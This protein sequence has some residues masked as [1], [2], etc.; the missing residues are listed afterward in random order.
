MSIY[1][2]L[3][4]LT[5]LIGSIVTTI[6]GKFERLRDY[7]AVLFSLISALFASLL[8]PSAL[9][10]KIIHEQINWLSLYPLNIKAGILAD[11]LS[12]IMANI[13]GWISFLIMFYSLEYMKGERDL[14]RYWFF[15]NFFIG[16][17]QLIV[18]SDNLL[19]LFF[20]W[21]GVGLA[22]YALIGFWHTDEKKYWVGKEGHKALGIDLAYSPTH[23][24]MKAFLFTKL[25][26]I[27]FLIG[28]LILFSYSGT[29]EYL[30][31]AEDTS[32]ARDL[33]S[34][35]LLP[36]VALL[37]FG[38]AVGKSAQF[39]LHE[40][41][42]DAM[43]G[44]TSVS[45]LIH[46]ATMVKAGVF[47]VA[48]LGPIFYLASREVGSVY[49]F[50][51]V[52]A[53][54]GVFT[55]FL[56]ATQAMVSK[57]LKKVIAYSTVSQIGYMMLALGVAGLSS[58]FALAY[59]ASFFHLMSHSIFKASLF[60]GAGALIHVTGT[61]FID[62][63]GGLRKTMKLTYLSM[64]LAGLSLAGIPPFSGFWSKEAILISTYNF[65][66]LFSLALITAIITAFYTFRM[67]GMIFFGEREVSEET[68]EVN[69]KFLS[70]YFTLGLSSLI[71]GIVSPFLEANLE[72]LF[73]EYLKE[74][75]ITSFPEVEVN[76]LLITTLSLSAVALGSLLA[77]Y[78]YINKRI[79]IER[80]FILY[81]FFND[82]WYINSLYYIIFLKGTVKV[83]NG[84]YKYFETLLDKGNNIIPLLT[85]SLSKFS[86]LFDIYVVDG[87]INSTAFLSSIFSR[88]VRKIQTGIAEHYVFA[89]A[90][91]II[92]V[93][94]L[95]I[96]R[97]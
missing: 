19:Q 83:V 69:F 77:Y 26:D 94:L 38:G 84:L 15:M 53:W 74:F 3:V 57:E 20:G 42:P 64:L 4:W 80:E 72:N 85:I 8:I 28:L 58:N 34:K 97:L 16:N 13:V 95:L 68:H 44:P 60:M 25:G 14:T 10:G 61:K 67:L 66:P 93:A 21:E 88:I 75:K 41:L 5:P 92:I 43:A 59:T 79:R 78:T 91:G 45:A 33:N 37:I 1:A 9:E 6:I 32:W 40:W 27:S 35:G 87:A 24:G 39:P 48:R 46:A 52:V 81:K 62:E 47:L 56:A 63:M 76:Y 12:I 54:I 18:L 49:P 2:W 90:L 31:L 70:P 65:L 7:L 17:M 82:R 30:K 36:L 50:F 96:G 71:L 11:P 51:E 29:F 89:F 23:A 73:E 22:S 55:A 86:N